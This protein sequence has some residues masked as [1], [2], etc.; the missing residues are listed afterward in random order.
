MPWA[1][2]H[3]RDVGPT[4]PGDIAVSNRTVAATMSATTSC[5]HSWMSTLVGGGSHQVSPWIWS[6]SIG[7]LELAAEASKGSGTSLEFSD[8]SKK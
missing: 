7:P 5:D 3:D 4:R 8:V 6:F 2:S 1:T